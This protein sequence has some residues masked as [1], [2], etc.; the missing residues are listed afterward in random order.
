MLGTDGASLT[1]LVGVAGARPVRKRLWPPPWSEKSSYRGGITGGDDGNTAF[2]F[3]E[4]L[5]C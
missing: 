1:V 2:E 3:F 4:H 5:G